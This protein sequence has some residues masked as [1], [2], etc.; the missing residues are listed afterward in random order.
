MFMTI[1]MSKGIQ[2][3]KFLD[4]QIPNNTTE[5]TAYT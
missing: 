1:I 3:K 5:Q 2:N 4:I